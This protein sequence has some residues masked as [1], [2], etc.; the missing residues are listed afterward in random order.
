MI[1]MVSVIE[2]LCNALQPNQEKEKEK[3]KEK[4]SLTASPVKKTEHLY[5]AINW[6]NLSL[7]MKI[8]F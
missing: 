1:L 2:K 3:E 5:Q 7:R 6:V 8:E 4:S